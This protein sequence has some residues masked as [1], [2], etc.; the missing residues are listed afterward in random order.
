MYGKGAILSEVM[1][2]YLTNGEMSWYPV[3]GS[4]DCVFHGTASVDILNFAG[5][6]SLEICKFGHGWA[7]HLNKV[8]Y[9]GW[10]VLIGTG[11]AILYLWRKSLRNSNETPPR[12]PR[13]SARSFMKWLL[14][15]ELLEDGT[16][17]TSDVHG[18]Y[19]GPSLSDN[20]Q[21]QYS[22][23]DADE[24]NDSDDLSLNSLS[25]KSSPCKFLKKPLLDLS[26]KGNSA[27]FKNITDNPMW[28]SNPCP[29]C[30]KGTCRLKKHQLPKNPSNTSSCYSESPKNQFTSTPDLLSSEEDQILQRTVASNKL[31]YRYYRPGV[32]LRMQGDGSDQVYEIDS[33]TPTTERAKRGQKLKL[34]G[35]N[36]LGRERWS[37]S[38]S[39]SRLGSCS[40]SPACGDPSC[41]DPHCYG[42]VQLGRD[43]SVDSVADQSYSMNASMMDLVQNAKEA[44]RLI[45]EISFDSQASDLDIDLSLNNSI[46]GSRAEGLNQFCNGINQLIDNCDFVPS[47][48]GETKLKSSRSSESGM[49]E[50]SEIF[51]ASGEIRENSVPD[52]QRLQRSALNGKELWKLT[53][54][55][56]FSEPSDTENAS[57]EW[58]SPVHGWHS[59]PIYKATL[60]NEVNTSDSTDERS[61]FESSVVDLYEWDNECL[62]QS[63]DVDMLGDNAQ[64]AELKSEMLN[65]Q[66]FNTTLEKSEYDGGSETSRATSRRSSTEI[67]MRY[68]RRLP[69]S[70][71]SSLER[72]L[73]LS[74]LS[75]FSTASDEVTLTNALPNAVSGQIPRSRSGSLSRSCSG[76]FSPIV[77][78][79]PFKFANSN[80]KESVAN[81]MNSSA[82]SEESGFLDYEGSM[83][84]SICSSNSMNSSFF[85]SSINLSPVKEAKEPSSPIEVSRRFMD[86]PEFGVGSITSTDTVIK[87]SLPNTQ[88]LDSRPKKSSRGLFPTS[89]ETLK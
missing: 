53:G 86:S 44:R 18:Y 9:S 49:S 67:N 26:F 2:W 88:V 5:N 83:D 78:D 74:R 46:F 66:G 12:S 63:Y 59:K 87:I 64:N 8:K 38:P 57:L 47:F 16:D 43:I 4:H 73:S 32:D 20:H 76:S 80:N 75:D 81:V 39:R 35:R 15:E 11:G 36:P 14:D 33:A 77:R 89:E 34:Y 55:T 31:T 54:F 69:P 17:D 40:S 42:L 68:V 27:R 85:T 62:N 61:S 6:V 28:I 24:E 30:E 72:E 29:K 79:L 48:P 23:N 37:L 51:D 45:R 25:A 82:Y 52:F 56:D 60:Y 10:V 71:R 70:G 3:Q 58:E 41:A 84:S 50:L 1:S 7:T 65:E 22:S 19:F 13:L 21:G